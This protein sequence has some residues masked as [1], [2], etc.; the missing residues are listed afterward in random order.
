MTQDLD[1][2]NSEDS[3]DDDHPA[4]D[5]DIETRI[6]RIGRHIP[7]QQVFCVHDPAPNTERDPKISELL[8]LRNPRIQKPRAEG[9]RDG[10]GRPKTNLSRAQVGRAIEAAKNIGN[11]ICRMLLK[12]T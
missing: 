2:E 12:L 10:A 7:W 3:G 8:T 4:P 11:I 1:L 6:A 9:E 5:C